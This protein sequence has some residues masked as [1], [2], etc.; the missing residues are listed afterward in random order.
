MP[1]YLEMEAGRYRFLVSASFVTEVRRS[2]LAIDGEIDCRALFGEPSLPGGERV[3]VAVGGPD[4][5]QVLVADRVVGTLA[6]AEEDFAAF[7]SCG[8]GRR[9]FDAVYHRRG[10]AIL[11]RWKLS[12]KGHD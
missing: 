4:G 5:L 3:R 7:P 11:P 10:E 1:L 2:A 12:E 9:W 6:A 8:S